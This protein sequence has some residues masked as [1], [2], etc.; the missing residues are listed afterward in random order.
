MPTKKK[1]T[2]SLFTSCLAGALVCAPAAHASPA[3]TDPTAS[4]SAADLRDTRNQM[5]RI[6]KAAA[7]ADL[8]RRIRKELSRHGV[9]WPERPALDGSADEVCQSETDLS[10][11]VERHQA[12]LSLGDR[13]F[14]ALT[15]ADLL[16]VLEVLLA[17]EP[18]TASID[19]TGKGEEL[20][21]DLAQLQQFWDVDAAA[22][23]LK[24]LSGTML[25][26][27]VRVQRLY[28]RIGV[29]RALAEFLADAISRQVTASPGLAGGANPILTLNAFAI[30]PDPEQRPGGLIVMGKGLLDVYDELGQGEVAPQVV[31]AH[32]YAH[33]LQYRTGMIEPGGVA[34]PEGTRRTELHADA[35][36]TYFTVH[37][38]GGHVLP[39]RIPAVEQVLYGIGDCQVDSTGHHGTPAQRRRAGQWGIAQA[40]ASE[41]QVLTVARFQERYE[42]ALPHLLTGAAAQPDREAA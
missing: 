7:G 27:R 33:Q 17:D 40:R 34:T 28:E 24:G 39:A 37:S 4:A 20:E 35:S 19:E 36:A 3:G 25:A 30:A 29:P 13:I 5:N 32:E 2:V 22:V 8:E 10:R 38:R 23:E 9:D 21:R 11:A 1:I 18:R 26:D 16:P 31:L 6:R 14:V 42:L 41:P 15:F 12:R